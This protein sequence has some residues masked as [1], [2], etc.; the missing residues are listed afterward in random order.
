MAAQHM[1]NRADSVALP[2]RTAPEI[3]MRL[4]GALLALAVSAVHVADQG[5]V[6][7]FASPHWMGWGY[8][9][10]EAG[11][12]LTA[13]ILL[14]GPLAAAPSRAAR[15]TWSALA[16]RL[17]WVAGA[18]L[19][20]GPFVAYIASRTVGM[21]GD[22]RDVGKWVYWVGTVSLLVEAALVALSVTM[23]LARRHSGHQQPA[24]SGRSKIWQFSLPSDSA[25]SQADPSPHHQGPPARCPAR[26][27]RCTPERRHCR[28]LRSRPSSSAASPQAGSS[29]GM[30]ATIRQSAPPPR[31]AG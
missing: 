19:G 9:L 3:A 24:R 31:S 16:R 8:R 4:V 11:G 5:G 18:L 10:I 2:A 25:G 7:A 15:P 28:P 26:P 1:T 14:L 12:V 13:A 6:T 22:A 27:A 30:T 20:A 21:P 17:G 23:L 29:G